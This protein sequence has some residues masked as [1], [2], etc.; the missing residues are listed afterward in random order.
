MGA[1]RCKIL[2]IK[3]DSTKVIED[4]INDF[5]STKVEKFLSLNLKSYQNLTSSEYFLEW[6]AVI[7]YIPKV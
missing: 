5:L 1:E 7:M 6:I 3:S 4:R 2:Y